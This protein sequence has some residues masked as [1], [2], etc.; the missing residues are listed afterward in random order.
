MTTNLSLFKFSII[1]NNILL[2]TFV[3][4]IILILLTSTDSRAMSNEGD[5][6]GSEYSYSDDDPYATFLNEKHQQ[7]LRIQHAVENVSNFIIKP[8]EEIESIVEAATTVING[9]KIIHSNFNRSD[10][11]STQ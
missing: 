11:F 2:L 4:G 10:H 5:E 1:K 9:Q 3:W 6:S 8:E 7:D